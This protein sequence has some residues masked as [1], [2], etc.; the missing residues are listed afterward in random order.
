MATMKAD[1]AVRA[2]A[3]AL[4]ANLAS[5]A[6]EDDL[7]GRVVRTFVLVNPSGAKLAALCSGPRNQLAAPS[8]AGLAIK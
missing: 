8:Q 3:A 5:S 1:T 6:T 2:K 7:L 4:W